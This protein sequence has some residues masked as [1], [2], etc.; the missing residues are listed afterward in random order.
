MDSFINQF[1]A[2]NFFYRVTID[3]VEFSAS[4]VSGLDHEVE[5]IEYRGG[6]DPIF[7]KKVQL[8]LKKN[9]ELE[10]K[11]GFTD[12]DDRFIE[13]WER[14]NDKDFYMDEDSRFNILVE[15]MDEHENT[16]QAWNL[17]E[18][19]P[20]K[21]GGTALKADANEVYIESMKFNAREMFTTL[22]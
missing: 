9:I 6:D 5:K 18:V 10:V 11:K 22:S 3:G 7:A 19:I 12:G 15:L 4:E 16:I 14:V 13:L 8:G 2:V 20:V 17:T 1:K 21:F